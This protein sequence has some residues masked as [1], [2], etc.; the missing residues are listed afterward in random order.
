MTDA[1]ERCPRCGGTGSENHLMHGVWPN[2]EPCIEAV[3]CEKCDGVGS[4]DN[5][6]M[7]QTTAQ[8]QRAYKE[9]MKEAGYVRLEGYVSPE[10][11]E[12]YKALGGEKWLRRAIDRA[13]VKT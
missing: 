3:R 10:Q 6:D 12:K 9:S 5:R 8:R 1:K 2:G 13:K 4:I 7:A 11:R